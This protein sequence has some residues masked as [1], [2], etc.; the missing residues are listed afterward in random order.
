[1]IKST[2]CVFILWLIQS[3]TAGHV[4]GK[5]ASASDG[6]K[7]QS[8]RAGLFPREKIVQVNMELR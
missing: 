5:V 6:I 3:T 7:D 1:M 4:G 8:D 2:N